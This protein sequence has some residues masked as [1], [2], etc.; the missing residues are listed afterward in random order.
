M[1]LGLLVQSLELGVQNLPTK[2]DAPVASGN[3]GRP[4]SQSNFLVEVS[5]S[6]SY[7]EQDLEQS[8]GL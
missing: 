1:V 7:L 2:G 4:G 5:Y 3:I 8:L 6:R